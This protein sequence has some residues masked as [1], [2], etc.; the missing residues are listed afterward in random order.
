MVSSIRSSVVSSESVF[1][2]DSESESPSSSNYE[3]A[4]S[5]RVYKVYG[6]K[7]RKNDDSDN[8]KHKQPDQELLEFHR[9]LF[10]L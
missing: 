1:G 8:E 6:K 5:N 4:L 9:Q 2:S 7:N 10:G 3:V